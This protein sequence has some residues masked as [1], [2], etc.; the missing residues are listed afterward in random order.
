MSAADMTLEVRPPEAV[1]VLA[2]NPANGYLNA[3]NATRL[4]LAVGGCPNGFIVAGS[5]L[6]LPGVSSWEL[7]LAGKG[8]T[9]DCQINPVAFEHKSIGFLNGG[10]SYTCP[11]MLDDECDGI[12]VEPTSWGKMKS[13]YR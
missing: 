4:L 7:C 1:S 9:V 3:G 12:A 11:T 8:L 13:L 2:F 5:W 6:L 10:S